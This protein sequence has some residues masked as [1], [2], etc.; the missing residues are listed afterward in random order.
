V[1][2]CMLIFFVGIRVHA[3]GRERQLSPAARTL[4]RDERRR[5]RRRPWTWQPSSRWLPGPIWILVRVPPQVIAVLSGL[6]FVVML[7]SS[8]GDSWSEW[9]AL[10]AVALF[11]AFFALRWRDMPR[12]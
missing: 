2:V 9:I 5:M 12:D 6:L 10:G 11:T 7:A 3:R 4:L 8:G 1:L